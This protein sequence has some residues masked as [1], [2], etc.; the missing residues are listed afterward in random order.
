MVVALCLCWVGVPLVS[1][2]S[3]GRTLHGMRHYTRMAFGNLKVS[4]GRKEWGE[5]IGQ[6]NTARPQIWAA[7]SSPLFKILQSKGFFALLIG[8]ISGHSLKLAGFA[9]VNDTDLIFTAPTNSEVEV[10]KK[11]QELVATWEALLA[12]TGGTGTREVFLVYGWI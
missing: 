8:A 6:G 7:V 2:A 3:M 10:A 11:M 9:F 4:Q 1:V 12:A 5:P